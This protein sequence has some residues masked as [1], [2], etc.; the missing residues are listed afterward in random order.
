MSRLGFRGGRSEKRWYVLVS[1]ASKLVYVRWFDEHEA[2]PT[3]YV[4]GP[5]AVLQNAVKRGELAASKAGYAFR[6]PEG[7]A[8]R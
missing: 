6:Y 4:A 1:D 8:C 5:F 3:A 7:G 2:R